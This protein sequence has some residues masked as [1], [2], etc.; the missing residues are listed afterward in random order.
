MVSYYRRKDVSG[1]SSPF[2]RQEPKRQFRRY[3][4]GTA[5]IVLA[6]ALIFLLIY[7]LMVT[8]DA[9]IQANDFSFHSLSDYRSAVNEQLSHF[10][11]RN[12]ISF[13]QT[14]L[15]NALKKQ[16]PEIRSVQIEL[17]LLS[18]K[19]TVN[20]AIDQAS[21]FL[22]SKGERFII[23]SSGRAVAK[24]SK[25]PK[26]KNLPVINDNS[27]FPVSLGRQLLSSNGID[28]INTVIAQCRQANINI[29]S[30]TLP[31]VPQELDLRTTDQTYYVKFFLG[32]DALTQTGQYIAARHHFNESHQN[33]SQYLDV[34]VAGKI[35]FK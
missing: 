5:D 17:P 10:N 2:A 9:K 6:G 27:G 34:R 24:A 7:S 20:L 29:A 31:A 4:Y 14:G 3:I 18:Q 13:D 21:F 16:F 11:D 25:L 23:D 30:L 8:P 35:F 32:G 1:E 22:D 33:P 12:K 15:A 28:F 26:I 19:P